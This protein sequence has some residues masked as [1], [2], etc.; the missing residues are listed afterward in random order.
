MSKKQQFRVFFSYEGLRSTNFKAV[1]SR[2]Q[3]S[4]KG[5]LSNGYNYRLVRKK[6]SS[7]TDYNSTDAVNYS[8][9]QAFITSRNSEENERT[10]SR[11]NTQE[12]ITDMN[13]KVISQVNKDEDQHDSAAEPVEESR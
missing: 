13:T 4:F 9:G 5:K 6:C 1:A 7:K 10:S 8:D 2:K 12:S 11:C 3:V